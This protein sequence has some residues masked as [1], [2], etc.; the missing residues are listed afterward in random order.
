MVNIINTVIFR[1]NDAIIKTIIC[2]YHD[3]KLFM[4]SKALVICIFTTH[5]LGNSD[6]W[7]GPIVIN[8][9]QYR[10]FDI[11]K[12][13]LLPTF[14]NEHKDNCEALLLTCNDLY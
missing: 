10:E 14:V 9:Q 1:T 3:S 7:I 11:F 13:D 5:Y 2:F 12:S 4:N 8:S 6:C